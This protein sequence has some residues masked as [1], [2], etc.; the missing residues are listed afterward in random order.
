[1]MKQP[2]KKLVLDNGREFVGYGFGA[3][4]NAVCEISFN[5]SVVGYQEIISDPSTTNQIVVMTYPTIGNYGINDEDFESKSVGIGG[6]VVREYCDTPSNFRYTKTINEVMEECSIPGIYGVDT[7]MITRVIRDN[8]CR[9]AAIVLLDTTTE[10][11]LQM[12]ANCPNNHNII[13]RVSCRKRWYSRTPNH[14]YDVVAIDCGIKLNTV[15]A[16]NARGC[17]VVIVPYNTPIEDILAFNPDGIL[18]SNGPSNP[19]DL[20]QVV[21]LIKALRSRLPIFGISLGHQLIALAYGA[22]CTEHS[23]SKA[24][25]HPIRN[26]LTGHI[27]T[28]AIDNHFTIDRTSLESTPLN[29]THEDILEQSIA[30]VEYRHDKIFSV[31]F[32]PEGAPGSN[33]NI[34]LFDKFIKL[35]EEN[36]HA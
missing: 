7:R 22:T 14:K 10:E 32:H 11:A 25:S 20:P 15:A 24:G 9:K 2:D 27:R 34:S 21:E 12:I 8:C 29:I 33:D 28:A 26:T 18:I 3:N 13:D 4:N 1:M 35:M 5:S 19:N 36:K 17:N 31:Q 6:L 30:G 16:L 23:Y